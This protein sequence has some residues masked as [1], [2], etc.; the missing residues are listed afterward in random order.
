[1]NV[2]YNPALVF[3]AIATS[4]VSVTT[5]SLV[6]ATEPDKSRCA[7]HLILIVISSPMPIGTVT[8]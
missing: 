8:D 6:L 3:L 4:S 2:D 7:G 1:M 5:S